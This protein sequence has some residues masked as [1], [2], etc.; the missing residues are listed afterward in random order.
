MADE[1]V[2]TLEIEEICLPFTLTIMIAGSEQTL[3]GMACAKTTWTL[4]RD[5]PMVLTELKEDDAA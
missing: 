3:V 4:K 2:G 5:A 1:P